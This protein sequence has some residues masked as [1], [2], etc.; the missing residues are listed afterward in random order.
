MAAV[1]YAD[2]EAFYAADERR[3]RSGEVDFG[4]WWRHGRRIYRISWV[5]VTGELIAVQLSPPTVQPFSFGAEPAGL[6]RGGLGVVVYGGEARTVSVLARIDTEA[7][8]EQILDGWA[9]VCG[10]EDSLVWIRR[11]LADAGKLEAGS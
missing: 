8:L 4:V 6:S 10:A 5:A 1:G 11:Q 9:E 3:R 2:V 7:E